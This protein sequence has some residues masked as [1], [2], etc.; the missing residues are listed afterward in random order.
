MAVKQEKHVNFFGRAIVKSWYKKPSYYINEM[1]Q[2]M[3]FS[4][5]SLNK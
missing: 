1:F 2:S 5:Q 3:V 4:A